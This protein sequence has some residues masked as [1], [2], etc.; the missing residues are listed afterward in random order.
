MMLWAWFGAFQLLLLTIQDYRNN[1]MIDDRKNYF[2]MGMSISL[3]MVFPQPWFYLLPLIVVALGLRI[4]LG[5]KRV[6]GAGDLNALF[7]IFYGF[8]IINFMALLTYVILLGCAAA[9]FGI[10][11]HH[12]L[13]IK[14]P[15][16]FMIVIFLSFVVA[17]LVLGHYS[18]DVAA[19]FS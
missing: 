7:W 13:G 1:M 2:M 9:G 10:I 5:K 12:L 18:F 14:K 6:M 4:Y 16:P 8:G 19:Y 3:L 11:K 15:S 17:N